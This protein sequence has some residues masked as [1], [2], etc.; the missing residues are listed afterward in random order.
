MESD[1]CSNYNECP[2]VRAYEQGKIDSEWIKLYCLGNWKDCARF[3]LEEIGDPTVEFVLPDG[4]VEDRL[5]K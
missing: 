2:I 4:S 1:S 3:Q 5:R